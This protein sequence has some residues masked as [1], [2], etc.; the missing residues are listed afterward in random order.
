MGLKHLNVRIHVATKSEE[1]SVHVRLFFLRY[2]LRNLH[3]RGRS[4]G[5]WC[6]DALLDGVKLAADARFFVVWWYQ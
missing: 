4:V 3:V 2:E 6:Q 5:I 1:G